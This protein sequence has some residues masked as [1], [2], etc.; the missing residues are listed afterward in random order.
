MATKKTKTTE[1]AEKEVQYMM[2]GETK[3]AVNNMK[4]LF[5]SLEYKR[6]LTNAANA[7]G[8]ANLYLGYVS[9]VFGIAVAVFGLTGIISD[10]AALILILAG[11]FESTQAFFG[12]RFYESYRQ[13]DLHGVPQNNGKLRKRYRVFAYSGTA[14]T[15]LGWL[16]IAA[17]IITN[18]I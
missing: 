5:N 15:A 4:W 1:T 3:V 8:F 10:I 12:M 13:N 14:I 9:I 2:F 11:F 16:T 6:G 17:S 18:L 7:H